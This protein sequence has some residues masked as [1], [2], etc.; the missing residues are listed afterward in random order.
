MA[1]WP[2]LENMVK[3]NSPFIVM[4]SYVRPVMSVHLLPVRPLSPIT[5]AALLCAQDLVTSIGVFCGWL[6]VL[7]IL[8]SRVVIF[9]ARVRVLRPDNVP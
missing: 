6:V 5:A 3:H 2:S 1:F 9:V 8:S 7:S 4:H